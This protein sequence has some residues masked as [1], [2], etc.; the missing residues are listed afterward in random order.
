MTG[1]S[2]AKMPWMIAR[3]DESSPPGV[4]SSRRKALPCWSLAS[5]RE[6]VTKSAVTGLM[7]E[8]SLTL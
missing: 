4:S 7:T 8:A 5:S 3:I 6:L 2:E 1:R